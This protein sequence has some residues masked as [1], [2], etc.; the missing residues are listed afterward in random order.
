MDRLRESID[1]FINNNVNLTDEEKKEV[2]DFFNKHRDQIGL[3]NW[4]KEGTLLTYDYFKKIIDDYYN[5]KN[6]RVD[7][8]SQLQ[9]GVDY[10]IVYNNN[11]IIGY[12]VLTFKGSCTLASNNVA[13][14]VWSDVDKNYKEAPGFERNVVSDF[15]QKEENGE[16]LYGGAKWCTAY[17]HTSKHWDEYKQVGMDFVYLIGNVPTGKVAIAYLPKRYWNKFYTILNGGYTIP[18]SEGKPVKSLFDEC[19]KTLPLELFLRQNFRSIWNA[20]NEEI[21][22]KYEEVEEIADEL[23]G[24]TAV[25]DSIEFFLLAIGATRDANGFW[26]RKKGIVG[27][28]TSNFIKEHHISRRYMV[29]NGKLRTKW[30]VWNGTFDCDNWGL[31]TLENLPK[32]ITGDFICTNNLEDFTEDDI[33]E[34]TR[35]Q[36][37]KIFN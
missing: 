6:K 17:K 34:G 10:N 13:P 14:E 8:L 36:G 28:R 29:S 15:P 26:S 31:E 25:E 11:G 12:E 21:S 19:F 23:I 3:V 9:E 18:D 20:Y 27:D 1:R 33:P 24:S 35:I 2:K 37:R 7:G 30:N 32:V 16:K 5:R 4:Q 22:E